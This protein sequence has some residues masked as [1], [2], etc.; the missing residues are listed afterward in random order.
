M[1]LKANKKMITTFITTTLVLGSCTAY[2]NSKKSLSRALENLDVVY[3]YEDIYQMHQPYVEWDSYRDNH[4]ETCEESETYL[5]S[6]NSADLLNHIIETSNHY[7]KTTADDLTG[8]QPLDSKYY[9][10]FQIALETMI[11]DT[12]KRSTKEELKGFAHLLSELKVVQSNDTMDALMSYNLADNKLVVYD[13]IIQSLFE[14]SESNNIMAEMT[15]NSFKHELSHMIQNYCS[16]QEYSARPGFN[17]FVFREAFA[18]TNCN[19]IITSYSTECDLYNLF[20]ISFLFSNNRGT[21]KIDDAVMHNDLETLNQLFYNSDNQELYKVMSS[22]HFLSPNTSYFLYSYYQLSDIH[23]KYTY[24]QSEIKKEM[25]GD[26]SVSLLKNYTSHLIKYAQNYEL[27]MGNVLYFYKWYLGYIETIY[28]GHYM[29]YDNE[30][31][32]RSSEYMTHIKEITE[33]LFSHLSDLYGENMHDIYQYFYMI[34][35][36]TNEDEKTIKYNPYQSLSHMTEEMKESITLDYMF[37]TEANN[38][39]NEIH[40]DNF[41][42]KKEK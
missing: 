14:Y 36:E 38:L 9:S 3:E 8:I 27:P 11:E 34:S 1:R 41:V 24:N 40:I 15:C 25:F 42:Y 35:S 22:I 17:N 23:K 26:C 28:I 5:L 18:E 19:D 37:F 29:S 31:E 39:L 2:I 7:L 12:K 32:P 13:K 6:E 33:K 4:I 21:K 30:L 16:C 20:K 10:D